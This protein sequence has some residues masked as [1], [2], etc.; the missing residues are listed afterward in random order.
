MLSLRKALH[1][2]GQCWVAHDT[3]SDDLPAVIERGSL[4]PVGAQV[5]WQLMDAG[6]FQGVPDDSTDLVTMMQGLHHIPQQLLPQFLAEVV[7]VLRPGGLFIVREHDASP[8]LMPM[9]DLAHSVFNA[10]MGVTDKE[11]ER[12]LRAFRPVSEWRKILGCC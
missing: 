1:M 2:K 5:H 4:D 11:E 10:V 12:E 8:S 3:F 9:L 6:P 7:R